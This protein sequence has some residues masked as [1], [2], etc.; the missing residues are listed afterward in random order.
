MAHFSILLFG[1]G[2]CDLTLFDIGDDEF[3]Q[4]TSSFK[5]AG[6]DYS[7]LKYGNIWM[8]LRFGDLVYF[9]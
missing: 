9:R 8:T 4:W 2:V 3:R 7:K 6:S 1:P 5:D